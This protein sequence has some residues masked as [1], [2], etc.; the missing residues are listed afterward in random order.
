MAN[1]IGT[2]LRS[3]ACED[4]KNS[5]SKHDVAQE[6]DSQ[7]WRHFWLR[8]NFCPLKAFNLRSTFQQLTLAST[9]GPYAILAF[10]NISIGQAGH[11]SSH[12]LKLPD[13]P[14]CSRKCCL[15]AI[16]LG[17]V[18]YLCPPGAASS[19]QQETGVVLRGK[20]LPR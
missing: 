4:R 16:A 18:K 8:C 2:R 19:A 20:L 12:F 17:S 10:R 3:F 14:F 13:I 7:L 1:V 6:N 11:H 9:L 5:P 15:L